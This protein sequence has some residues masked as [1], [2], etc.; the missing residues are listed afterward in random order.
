MLK[1]LHNLEELYLMGFPGEQFKVGEPEKPLLQ[2]FKKLRIAFVDIYGAPVRSVC[3]N[4]LHVQ[5]NECIQV[6]CQH[7]ARG[8]ACIPNGIAFA[9]TSVCDSHMRRVCLLGE[10]FAAMTAEV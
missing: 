9:I 3:F 5:D 6:I 1:C 4:S 10:K 2:T 7:K 8:V